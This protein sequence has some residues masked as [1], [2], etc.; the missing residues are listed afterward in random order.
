MAEIIKKLNT[1]KYVAKKVAD[2]GD[3]NDYSIVPIGTDSENVD[4]PDKRT[5]EESLVEIESGK[6]KV[7]P[8]ETLPETDIKGYPFIYALV[9]PGEKKGTFY[10]YRNGEW[11]PYGN[12]TNGIWVGTKEECAED[13]DNI[14]TGTVV[15]IVK[16][17]DDESGDAHDHDYVCFITKAPTYSET[18]VKT[19]T[20]FL[21]GDSYT[22]EI[23]AL[24]DSISPAGVIRIGTREY[25]AWKDQVSFEIY[26]NQNQTV[27]IEGTDNE[28]GIK[29][30][31]YHLA[32]SGVNDTSIGT[33]TWTPYTAPFTIE[34]NNNYIVYARITDNADNVTYICSD[35]IVLDN[36]PP[37]FDGLE[38]GETYPTGT[39]LTVEEGAV[40]TVNGETVELVNNTY[41]FSEVMDN[42]LLSIIDRAMNE[43]SIIITIVD[44]SIAPIGEEENWNYTLNDADKTITLN[45]YSSNKDNDY[46]VVYS[47]YNINEN[48]YR[49]KIKSNDTSSMGNYMFSSTNIRRIIFG[50]NLDT[51]ETF[52]MT[53]MFR[54]SNVQSIHFGNFDTSNTTNMSYMFSYTKL[55]SLDLSKFNVSKVTDMHYMFLRS[56]KLS[57]LSLKNW[58]TNNV[59]DMSYMFY[60]LSN[61]KTIDMSSFDTSSVT[62]MENM[63]NSSAFTELNLGSFNTENVTN[64]RSMF[65]YLDNLKTINLSNFN[66]KNVKDMSYMFS[67]SQGYTTLDLRNFN[68]ENVETMERMFAASKNL[69][70]IKVSKDKWKTSQAN[71]RDMFADGCGISEV[72]YV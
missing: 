60:Y 64:M 9:K 20:C 31:A 45:Y 8:V 70:E 15:I 49:T 1:V 56:E 25:S 32:A 52:N 10:E 28:T 3:E 57:K 21:C 62:N 53:A 13:F 38:D 18:G 72:T 46:V 36:I 34:P 68:T 47:N 14:E 27:E 61:L 55:L 63:F 17:K 29:E 30:I 44:T 66:T 12:R 5:V 41:T 11:I 42:C 59:T 6:A 35:G 65:Q 22:E 33:V 24:S 58:N 16:K 48:I 7:I 26:T 23:P 54:F 39:V 2:N 51:S 37:I 67:F 4:R 19:Y 43:N 50:D 71:V 40:L 69:K